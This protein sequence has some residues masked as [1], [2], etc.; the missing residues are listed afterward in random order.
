MGPAATAPSGPPPPSAGS[1]KCSTSRRASRISTPTRSAPSA[2][3]TWFLSTHRRS[4]QRG[5]RPSNACLSSTDAAPTYSLQ[6]RKTL[7]GTMRDREHFASER[8]SSSSESTSTSTG[9]LSSSCRLCTPPAANSGDS[10]RQCGAPFSPPGGGAATSGMSHSTRRVAKLSAS[11][12]PRRRSLAW[13][14][15]S[16]KRCSVSPRS[17]ATSAS[18]AL[19][20]A[21][22]CSFACSM[23]ASSSVIRAQFRC[24]VS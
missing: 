9:S 15:R 3:H 2:G 6:T 5:V 24:W 4:A 11:L 12:T 22:P 14:S 8:V 19:S 1:G 18:V 21:V 17:C 7:W 13:W 16:A 20:T 10:H 23:D